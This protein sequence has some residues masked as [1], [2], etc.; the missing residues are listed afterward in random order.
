M[1]YDDDRGVGEP[2]NETGVDGKGL[3]IRGKHLLILDT[4]DNSAH[5]Q[6][7]MAEEL[8]MIPELAFT[9]DKDLQLGNY[10]LKVTSH[11]C[12]SVLNCSYS[13]VDCLLLFLIMFTC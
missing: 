5:T 4:I 9:E 7:M 3:V 6:R 8:M 1:L 10:N 11:L 13:I 12:V 2:L